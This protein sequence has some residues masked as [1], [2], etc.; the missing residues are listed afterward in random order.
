MSDGPGLP[1]RSYRPGSW[2]A[3]LGE[4]TTVLLP[5]GEGAR[6]P[7]L[8]RLVDDGAGFDE[9][10]DALIAQ[11]LRGLAGFVLL[12][13]DDGAVRIVVRGAARARLSGAGGEV[14]VAGSLGS[15][16][17]ERTVPGVTRLRVD[18]PGE[19]DE[20]I[21]GQADGLRVDGG[22]VRVSRIDQPPADAPAP[23]PAEPAVPSGPAGPSGPA[24]DDA[25]TQAISLADLPDRRATERLAQD[26]PPRPVAR[27]HFSTGERVDVDRVV[28]VGR[29]P[30]ARRFAAGEQPRLVS[31]DSPHQ[32]V[33]S[34]H[35][36]VRPGTGP[37]AGV[38]V[39]TDLGS[40]NG[41]WLLQPGEEAEEL[42]AGL[43]ERLRPGA[44]IDLGDGVT[45]R[46][47][48]D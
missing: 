16:W 43:A 36:E 35:L 8:W 4:R 34:T 48:A 24:Y 14:E 33:S 13:E 41:T 37:D 47:L 21:G 15:T 22:L 26:G 17:V 19:A 1:H 31:V 27:L 39:L 20:G 40:T 44:V 6:V 2:F 12:A 7:G 9:V 42:R 5:P 46:V 32:E 30:E 11:G 38:A 3:I 29:A 23:G 28:L 10:L 25:E 18:V 45:I